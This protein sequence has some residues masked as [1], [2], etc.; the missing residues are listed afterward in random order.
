M[1]KPLYYKLVRSRLAV[2]LVVDRHGVL[3]YAG[4]GTDSDKLVATA[5]SDYTRDHVF[6]LLAMRTPTP[7]MQRTL[8]MYMAMV[9][10]PRTINDLNKKI[11]MFLGGTEFQQRVW[12]HLVHETD[13]GSTTTYKEIA[14]KLGVPRASRAVGASCGRNRIA[15]AVP[16]HRVVSTRGDMRG[17]KWGITIK[18]QLLAEER[19]PIT[20]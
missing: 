4:I 1:K 13:C 5:T 9:E 6:C 19:G 8:D 3:H 20:K 15:L 2:I 17:Y 11:P 16:C 10:D 18:Q 12:D 7:E 14:E